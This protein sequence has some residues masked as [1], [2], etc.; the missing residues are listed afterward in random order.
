ML[1]ISVA[2][3]WHLGSVTAACLASVGHIV[4]GIDEDPG[5]VTALAQAR[6]PVAEP[7]LDEMTAREIANG[8]LCFSTRFEDTA[9]SDVVWVAY[10]TP[11]DENDAADVEFVH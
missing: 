11:V 10:D 8:R 5:V 3:M 7:G 4:V 9:R 6:P 2:G 1:T